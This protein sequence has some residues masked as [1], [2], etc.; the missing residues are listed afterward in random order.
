VKSKIRWAESIAHN[1]E[2]VDT[3][4]Y[5]KMKAVLA[6][7]ARERPMDTAN[8]VLAATEAEAFQ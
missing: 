7:M 3:N 1:V 4:T 6:A 5:L 8:F 2:E